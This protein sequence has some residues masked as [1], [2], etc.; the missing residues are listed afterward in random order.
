MCQ[1]FSSKKEKGYT[2]VEVAISIL[3]FAIVALGLSLPFS[4]SVSLTVDNK[5]INAANNLARS[6]LK[7][8]EA[9][10]SVQNNFDQGK[11]I[12]ISNSYNNNSKYTVIVNSQNISTDN[13]GIVVVRR[14]NI[15]Y[16]DNKGNILTDIYYDYNRPGG[17]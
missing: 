3:F 10:W 16:K 14:V 11:L 4:N 6:Y 5:N 9:N 15:K 7:D 17:M 12:Q 2:L 8:T 1:D 13:N